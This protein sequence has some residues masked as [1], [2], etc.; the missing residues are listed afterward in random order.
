MLLRPFSDIHV[1]FW[2]ANKVTR[3]FGTVVP[4]LPTDRETV[5]LIAG[6]LGL[7]HRQETWLRVLSIFSK[8]F[9]AV[10][11]V[12][13]NHFFYHND[14]FGRIPELK[15]KLS[16]PMNVHFLENESIDINGVVFFVAT[17]GPIFR[18]RIFSKCST[19]ERT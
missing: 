13:G 12:E 2:P 18:G 16:F 19:P 7:A 5:A 15:N 4:S 6:D 17:S 9:L 1:E 11:Y 3:I 14:F 8:Q 10:I